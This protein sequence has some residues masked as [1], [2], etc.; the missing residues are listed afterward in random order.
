MGY[1]QSWYYSHISQTVF[2]YTDAHPSP[3]QWNAIIWNDPEED[4]RG[5]YLSA[6]WKKKIQCMSS[7]GRQC[8]CRFG[9]MRE[10]N[11]LWMLLVN[12][13][14][15]GLPKIHRGNC[16]FDFVLERPAVTCAVNMCKW[17]IFLIFIAV[18]QIIHAKKGCFKFPLN[19]Y[20]AVVKGGL[21]NACS[22]LKAT[23]GISKRRLF[24]NQGW[25]YKKRSK[26]FVFWCPLLIS[27]CAFYFALW[28]ISLS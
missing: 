17:L 9:G 19:T 16:S 28:N 13:V 26:N 14:W 20:W 24:Y 5:Y 18:C 6:P 10:M 2:A 3:V 11:V 4:S 15:D 25:T 8:Y 23:Q 27:M 22:V 21:K 7:I 1:L 12:P